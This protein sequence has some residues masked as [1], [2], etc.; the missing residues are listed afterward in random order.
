VQRRALDARVRAG[1][2][3]DVVDPAT[4]CHLY[5]L[6]AT[7]VKAAAQLLEREPEEIA[8]RYGLGE[9]TLLRRLPAL[10]LVASGTL[11]P[12]LLVGAAG[13]EAIA[14]AR[15]EALE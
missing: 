3:D 14:Q 11:R 1:E 6:T 8:G 7:G 4:R 5:Y 15:A 13:A 12:E 10:D 2:A 9:R